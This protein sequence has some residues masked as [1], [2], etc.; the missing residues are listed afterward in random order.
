MKKLMMF[1]AAAVMMVSTQAHAWGDREQGALIG[2]VGTIIA[3]DIMKNQ[4]QQPV[5]APVVVQS[6]PQV[7]YRDP[8]RELSAYERGIRDR[9]DADLLYIEQEYRRKKEA[10]RQRAYM[11]G[12]FGECE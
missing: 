9:Y 5:T 10:A 2:I 6:V 12:R 8:Q 7:I 1:A 11:C 4:R 3:Q